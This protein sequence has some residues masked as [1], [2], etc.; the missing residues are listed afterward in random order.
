MT[1]ARQAGMAVLAVLTFG[2]CAVA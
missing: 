2:A 1:V